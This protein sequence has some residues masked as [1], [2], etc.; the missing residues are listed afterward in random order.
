MR[1]WYKFFLLAA[2]L[3]TEAAKIHPSHAGSFL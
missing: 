3:L 1:D 2:A